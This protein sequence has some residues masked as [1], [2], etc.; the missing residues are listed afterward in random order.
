MGY[1]LFPR[2]IQIKRGNIAFQA[3][4]QYY[5]NNLFREMKN[6]KV[7]LISDG[8]GVRDEGIQKVTAIFKEMLESKLKN[9]YIWS[10]NSSIKG[11]FLQKSLLSPTFLKKLAR[12]NVDIV[13]Y[14]PRACE[15]PAS[16]YRAWLIKLISGSKVFLISM[17]KRQL[18]R[19]LLPVLRMIS[20]HKIFVLSKKHSYWLRNLGF[21]AEAL[22]LGVDLNVFKPVPQ[23]KKDQIR[24]EWNFPLDKPI[25]LHVGH[26]THGRNLDSLIP[27]KK[28]GFYV[29]IISSRSFQNGK[30]LIERLVQRGIRIIAEYIPN[31]ERIYQASDAYVFPVTQE[32]AAIELPLSLLEA[33]A[34]NLP[35]VT[36]PFGAIPEYFKSKPEEGFTIAADARDLSYQTE[37]MLTVK[38]V[39]TREMVKGFSWYKMLDQ[40]IINATKALYSH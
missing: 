13:I 40:L 17:Q 20:P 32:G 12:S 11:R 19:H 18:P 23:E 21:D 15:T 3:G 4:L 36:T 10:I 7:G 26:L 24:R 29:V 30:E 14:I 6:L 22:T 31:I 5:L 27:L 8:I 1:F 38:N 25:A 35:I 34:T 2:G 39:R 33:M 37:K 9:V 16:F 28:A